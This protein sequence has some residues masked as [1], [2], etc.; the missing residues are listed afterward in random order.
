MTQPRTVLVADDDPESRRL[1]VQLLEQQGW[2]V[3]EAGSGQEVLDLAEREPLSLV[4]LD[5]R[6]PGPVDPLRA[7]FLLRQNPAHQQVPVIAVSATPS[8]EFRH[9]AFAAG[10]NAFMSKPVNLEQLLRQIDLVCSPKD[11]S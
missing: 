5:L 1:L 3:L 7:A 4:L 11:E 10:C 8:K 2:R 6:M 9:R